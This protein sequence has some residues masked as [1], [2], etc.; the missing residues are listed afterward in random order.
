MESKPFFKYKLPKQITC[1]AFTLMLVTSRKRVCTQLR[2]SSAI[3][4]QEFSPYPRWYFIVQSTK[5]IWG[6]TP[7]AH[8]IDTHFH[9]TS[10]NQG[11]FSKQERDLWERG[12]LMYYC[13]GVLG[14]VSPG[15]YREL[16]R[17]QEILARSFPDLCAGNGS[18]EDPEGLGWVIKWNETISKFWR[19]DGRNPIARYGCVHE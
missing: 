13:L 8:F 16:W 19:E 4:K 3:L 5:F 14:S 15:L 10:R 11:F 18:R 7:T 6:P 12:W 1:F 2:N 9:V 17:H